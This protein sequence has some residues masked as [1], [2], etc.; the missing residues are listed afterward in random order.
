MSYLIDQDG[1]VRRKS[2]LPLAD[3]SLAFVEQDGAGADLVLVH[4]FTDTSRSYSLL[5][6]F[7]AGH[8]LLIPDLR[9]HG[10]SIGAE[11]ASLGDFA[12]DVIALTRARASRRAILVGHSLGAMVTIE[13]YAKAPD[14]FD[15]VVLI[16]CSVKPELRDCHPIVTG[17][18]ALHDPIQPNDPFFADWHHCRDDVPRLFLD[19]LAEEAS[20]MPARRWRSILDIIRDVDLAERAQISACPQTLIMA[21]LEDPLFGGSHQTTMLTCLPKAMV[22]H[23]PDCGHN[24]HWEEPAQIAAALKHVILPGAADWRGTLVAG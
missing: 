9:G 13:A 15:A 12:A 10:A 2:H 20:V 7:L 1:W 23:L 17:V 18:D 11:P 16:A 24:P 6:P 22:M 21:G 4:G 14:L 8:R 3:G 19:K 5:M